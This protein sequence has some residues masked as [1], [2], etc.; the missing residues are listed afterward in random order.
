MSLAQWLVTL[1]ILPNRHDTGGLCIV[2]AQMIV[3]DP[4]GYAQAFHLVDYYVSSIVA[5]SIYLSPR[6]SIR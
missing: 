1:P 6:E 2:S 5:G 4:A 3:T